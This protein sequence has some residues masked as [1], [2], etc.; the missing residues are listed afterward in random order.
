MLLSTNALLAALTA[1]VF[2]GADVRSSNISRGSVVNPEPIQ[3][4]TVGAEAEAGDSVLGARVWMCNHL[5]DARD[6]MMRRAFNEIDPYLYGRNV[7]GMAEGWRLASEFGPAWILAPEFRDPYRSHTEVEW[8]VRQTLENPFLTPYYYVRWCVHP[9]VLPYWM[10]GVQHVFTPTETVAV[11]PFFQTDWGSDSMF[12][13]KYGR[14]SDGRYGGGLSAL[15][16]GVRMVWRFHDNY[17]LYMQAEEF[18][19]VDDEIRRCNGRRH[20]VN[21][22]NERFVV[23][24]GVAFRF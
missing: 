20:A 10:V 4:F 5:T 6:N 9:T 11:T 21:N 7:F 16:A 15:T 19:L 24:A 8:R 17:S 3:T 22:Q 12:T 13:A 23:T 14:S 1:S 2:G 18:A